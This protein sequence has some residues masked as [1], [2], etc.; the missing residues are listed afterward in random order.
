M[1]KDLM[2]GLFILSFVL[3]LGTIISAIPASESCS[4][5]DGGLNYYE[6]NFVLDKANNKQVFDSCLDNEASNVL[7]EYTCSEETEAEPYFK[8]EYECPNGCLDGACIGEATKNICTDSDRGI[9]FDVQGY[10]VSY[11]EKTYDSC[12]D[13]FKLLEYGCTQENLLSVSYSDCENGCFDGKCIASSGICKDNSP[14][15]GYTEIGSHTQYDVC[16]VPSHEESGGLYKD[17]KWYILVSECKTENCF[18]ADSYCVNSDEGG[19][20]LGECPNGCKEG[21]CLGGKVEDVEEIKGIGFRYAKWECYDGE[22]ESKGEESSCKPSELWQSYAEEF[23]VDKCSEET[24]KCGVNSFSVGGECL[25]DEISKCELAGYSC[26]SGIS[27]AGGEAKNDYECS[28]TSV[29]CKFEKV[30]EKEEISLICKNSCAFEDSCLPIG[31]RT[32]GKYCNING[33][34]LPQLGG[35]EQ[36]DNNFE[37][38]SNVCVS[39][40]CLETSLIQKILEWFR[41]LFGEE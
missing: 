14:I 31:V 35:G 18:R 34:I 41:K 25:D 37:C 30:K 11:G 24:G 3:G 2:L 23:C 15:K 36:C 26:V 9:N 17:G 6:K 33:E 38:G 28:G 12:K 22:S 4:D 29:C 1:K 40:Q 19:Y 7:I 5:P 13:K 20:K 10:V 8:K 21:V 39:G 27:C 32:E 16:A